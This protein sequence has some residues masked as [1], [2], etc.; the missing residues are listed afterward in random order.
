V[1]GKI[2]AYPIANPAPG[3]RI[4]SGFGNRRDPIIGR[5]AFHAGID[6]AVM[7]GTPIH[8][9]G[10]RHCHPGR[11]QRR[12][13][14]HDRNPPRLNGL[15]TR[16][17]HLSKHPRQEGPV[18]SPPAAKIARL[19]GSTGRSTGPHLHYE[20]REDNKAVNPMSFLKAGKRL[21]QYL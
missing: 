3:H 19:S 6:F 14:Q 2:R 15:T 11:P 18:R 16:Y 10:G 12:L 7:R 9:T 20:V 4:T 17:A 1:R 13:W 21:E 8:A 5:S